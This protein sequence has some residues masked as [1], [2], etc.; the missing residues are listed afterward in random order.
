MRASAISNCQKKSKLRVTLH[1]LWEIT[2][3]KTTWVIY[4]HAQENA[5][6]SFQCHEVSIK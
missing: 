2:G 6:K 1:A 3:N 5:E 4:L